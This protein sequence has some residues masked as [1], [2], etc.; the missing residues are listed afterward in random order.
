MK[1]HILSINSREVLSIS[2]KYTDVKAINEM[3]YDKLVVCVFKFMNTIYLM[4]CNEFVCYPNKLEKA[5]M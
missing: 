2:L 1:I 4:D 5:K 3:N